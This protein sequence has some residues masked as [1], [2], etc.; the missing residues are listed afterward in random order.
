[1]VLACGLAVETGWTV[2]ILAGL[3][4]YLETRLGGG[5][6]LGGCLIRNDE[7]IEAASV[8]ACS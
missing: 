8:A 7:R 5:V 6:K 4:G 3:A 2:E 1:V